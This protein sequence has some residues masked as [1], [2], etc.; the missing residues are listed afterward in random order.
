MENMVYIYSTVSQ[1]LHSK[2]MGQYQMEI[3][4]VRVCSTIKYIEI[5]RA[6]LI[7]VSAPSAGTFVVVPP[8]DVFVST[9]QQLGATHASADS[10][11]ASAL[12]RST[13]VMASLRAA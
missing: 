8:S 11:R 4:V 13:S 10:R 1:I 2:H 12:S 5:H 6:A 3:K 7:T 9:N